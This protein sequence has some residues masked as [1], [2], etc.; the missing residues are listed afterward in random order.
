L[1]LK[2]SFAENRILDFSKT[3]QRRQRRSLHINKRNNSSR[4][5]SNC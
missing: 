1:L 3:S 4:G 5:D 2:D